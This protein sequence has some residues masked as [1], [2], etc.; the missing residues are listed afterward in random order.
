MA[1]KRQR[2]MGRVAGGGT[3]GRQGWEDSAVTQE[4]ASWNTWHT[5]STQEMGVIIGVIEN[6][7]LPPGQWWGGGGGTE[8]GDKPV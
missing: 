1:L 7:C 3:R 6:S 5:A 4:G 8:G 2:A